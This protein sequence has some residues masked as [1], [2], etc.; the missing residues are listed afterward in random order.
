MDNWSTR[1]PLQKLGRDHSV[2]LSLP[3]GIFR[4]RFIVDGERRYIPDLPSE[5]DEMGQTFNLLDHH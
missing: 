1:R 4:Y 3:S 2:L 5:I